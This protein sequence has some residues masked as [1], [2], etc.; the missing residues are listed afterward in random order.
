[1]QP[2]EQLLMS[3]AYGKELL[4]KFSTILNSLMLTKEWKEFYTNPK[5]QSELQP[6][7]ASV[8]SIE[9]SVLFGVA[10]SAYITKSSEENGKSIEDTIEEFIR[11]MQ[12][13]YSQ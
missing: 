11:V 3:A 7:L 4:K 8:D 2:S 5:L 10:S 12:E 6:L 9:K 13:K 1:M